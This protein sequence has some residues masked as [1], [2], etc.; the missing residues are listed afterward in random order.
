MRYKTP[1]PRQLSFA[2]HDAFR[3]CTRDE[4]G[5]EL[6]QG[7]RK[8]YR[9][10]DPRRPLHLTLR[11][12][13]A[14]G[15][16]SMLDHK[17]A[18][19]VRHLVYRFAEKN[20]VKIHKYANSGNHLHLLVQSKRHEDFKAFLKTITGLIARAITGARKGKPAGK[21]WDSLAWSRVVNWGRDF[22]GVVDYILINEMEGATVWR[23]EWSR[24]PASHNR[25]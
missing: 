17:N 20:G 21:F 2:S 4:H 14:R 12:E 13:R 19:R 22:K 6:N 15:A 23:R 3:P 8:L 24:K 5:G 18:R 11:S 1:M 7:R 9:P 16:W 10:F 25:P